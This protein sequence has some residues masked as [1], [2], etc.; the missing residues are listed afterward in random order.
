MRKKIFIIGI[1]FIV[2]VLLAYPTPSPTISPRSLNTRHQAFHY[3][4]PEDLTEEVKPIPY[5]KLPFKK[6]DLVKN[7]LN[8]NELYDIYQG[9]IYS[10]KELD[11]HNNNPIH[12][13]VDINVPYGTQVISPVDGFAMSSYN[14]QWVREGEDYKEA[15]IDNE[16]YKKPIRKYQGKEIRLGLGYFVYI[17]V[18]AVNRFLELAHLSDIDSSIPFSPPTHNSK[19]DS[20]DPENYK[21]SI[22][23]IS[24]NPYWVAVKKGDP[25]GKVGHSGLTWGY[26]EYIEGT[27][28]PI[29]LD[30]SKFRSWD[31]P[32]VHLEEF[33]IN[34]KTKQKGWQR[35]PYAVY[36]TYEH[37][38]TKTRKGGMGK[39][40]LWILDKD[41]LPQFTK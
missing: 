1:G 21:T 3:P 26:D 22:E 5:L 8:K 9:W 36:D 31:I 6:D 14:T 33:Y 12:A 35:D 19:T 13:G 30:L 17:Y 34:Q 25:L 2:L 37:Y 23:D 39:D 32:H 4:H 18:P 11:I 38:P 28:R 10:Q 16:E 20:W 29:V 15:A 40:P 27:K 7:P 24:K 41:N